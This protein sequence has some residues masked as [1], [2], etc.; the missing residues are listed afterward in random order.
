MTR[1][2][3]VEDTKIIARTRT[4][5]EYIIVVVQFQLTNVKSELTS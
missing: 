2:V 1:A 4:F 5:N 3:L